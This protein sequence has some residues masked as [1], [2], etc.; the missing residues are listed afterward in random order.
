MN[1]DRVS[2]IMPCYN[3]AAFLKKSIASVQDQTYPFFELLIADDGSSDGSLEVIQS[4]DDSRIK[5]IRLKHSG[6]SRARNSALQHATGKW[7]AFL[8]ADDTWSNTFLEKLSD[9]LKKSPEASLAYCGWQNIGDSQKTSQPYIP[10]DYERDDKFKHLISACP[11]PIHAALAK[12]DD[13]LAIG[14]F[15][16]H[17]TQAE[18]YKLWLKLACFKKIIRVPEVLAFYHHHAQ[19]QASRNQFEAASQTWRVQW[20]FIQ[21]NIEAFEA[22]DRHRCSALIDGALL[23]KA[24]RFYWDRHLSDARKLFILLLKAGYGNW[25]D[26]KYMLPAMLPFSVYQA[27]IAHIDGLKGIHP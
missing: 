20:D 1:H 24:Y 16:E 3:A 21:E 17:L 5:P 15:D 6:V 7:L 4:I 8:D 12:T 19:T 2:I 18:D 27:F 14:G 22:S 10:P 25:G 11:W 13:I 23:N 9:A 26:L